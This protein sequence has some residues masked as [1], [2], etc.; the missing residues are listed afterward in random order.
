MSTPVSRSGSYFAEGRLALAAIA[1]S[2]LVWLPYAGRMRIIYRNWDSP[3]YLDIA[4]EGYVSGNPIAPTVSPPLVLAHFPLYPLLVRA[5]GFI[6]LERALLAVSVLATIAATAIFYRLARDVWRVESPEFLTLVF[7]LVPP[8]WVLYRSLGASEPLFIALVMASIWFFETDRIGW[9]CVAAGLAAVTRVSG[10]M[11]LP[12]WA[13]LLLLRGRSRSL[14]WL[15]LIPAGLAA[16]LV[17]TRVRF[18]SFFAPFAPNVEKIASPIPFS[19]L[20]W[21]IGVNLVAHAEFYIY[22]AFIY[23]LG[24]SR[25]RR[26]PVPMTYAAFQL[27]FFLCISSEDWSRYFLAMAPFALVLGFHDIL[28]SRAARWLLPAYAAVTLYYCWN[29]FPKNVC[30]EPVYNEILRR[31]GAA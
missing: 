6:G 15:A 1:S 25:L 8:R 30:P 22:L 29:V 11:I 16:Y 26:F 9:S 21:L 2:L 20:G 12:A 5:L 3:S 31:I 13:L 23:A 10:I 24:I 19:F 14:P 27:A 17:F 4:G 7:L 18:G 28:T